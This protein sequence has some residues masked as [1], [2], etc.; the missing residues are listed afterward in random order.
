MGYPAIYHAACA[1]L[2]RTGAYPPSNN[3]RRTIA[4]ALRA[5]R[6]IYGRERAQRERYLLHQIAGGW[7]DKETPEGHG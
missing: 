6:T 2:V 3:G 5:I 1:Y 7:P 4:R